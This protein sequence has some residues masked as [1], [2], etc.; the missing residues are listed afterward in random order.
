MSKPTTKYFVEIKF[1]D[2]SSTKEEYYAD[3]LYELE[4]K[5]NEDYPDGHEDYELLSEEANES[6]SNVDW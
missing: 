6:S 5:I 3:S 2:G 1:E 4:E